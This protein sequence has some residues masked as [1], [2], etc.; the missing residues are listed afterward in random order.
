MYDTAPVCRHSLYE[1]FLMMIML[2]GLYKTE[3]TLMMISLQS[4]TV[5]TIF[6]NF[7]SVLPENAENLR[8]ISN[9][10]MKHTVFF[11]YFYTIISFPV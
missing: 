11:S 1:N 6:R 3:K 5:H 8:L 7:T 9:S 2:M 10:C 4:W